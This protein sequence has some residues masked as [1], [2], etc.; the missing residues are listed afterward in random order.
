MRPFGLY[1]DEFTV[2]ED[3]DSPLPEALL[4][5]FEGRG[6]VLANDWAFMSRVFQ[7]IIVSIWLL[8][9]SYIYLEIWLVNSFSPKLLV[10]SMSPQQIKESAVWIEIY[11]TLAPVWEFDKFIIPIWLVVAVTLTLI[12]NQFRSK[13]KGQ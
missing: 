6:K 2:P 13:D 8:G 7:L 9:S 11:K 3:F 10:D 1:S 4:N 12:G 5:A